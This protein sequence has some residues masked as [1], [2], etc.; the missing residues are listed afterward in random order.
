MFALQCRSRSIAACIWAFGNGLG[1]GIVA[2]GVAAIKEI[3]PTITLTF[4]YKISVTY[5]VAALSAGVSVALPFSHQE[6]SRS[7]G[8]V[9][10]GASEM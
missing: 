5:A 4:T 2:S 1:V 3:A 9:V 10:Q 6:R 8:V 7:E